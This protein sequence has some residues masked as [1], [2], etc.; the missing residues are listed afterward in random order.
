[1]EDV[2]EEFSIEQVSPEAAGLLG[3]QNEF[4]LDELD[5]WTTT[6]GLVQ[7]VI[8]FSKKILPEQDI[9]VFF[10]E[11]GLHEYREI[12]REGVTTVPDDSLFIG[13]L[14]M[15]TD[16]T[17]LN[18]LFT[19]FQVNEPVLEKVLSEVYHAHTIIPVVH[20]F[21]LLAFIL[22]CTPPESE[23]KT[24]GEQE[25]NF[26]NRLTER[27]TINLYASSIADQRL[28]ELLR[29]TQYPL[30]LQRHKTIKDVYDNLM[31]DIAKEIP[32]DLGICYAYDKELNQLIPFCKKGV[33]NAKPLAPGQGISGQVFESRQPLFI[34][35]RMSHPS[36]AIMQEEPFIDGSV[37][38][39]PVFT[40][41]GDLGVV[42]LVRNPE[43][44][45]PFGME[46]RYMLEIATAFTASE[47]TN[48]Q[49]YTRLDESN[50][51]VVESLTRALEAKD[52]YTEGHSAR[53]TKYAEGI[54]REMGY[55]EEKIHQ[56]RY[57]AM[58]HDI[59]KIGIPD[60]II[61][62]Q[63]RLTDSEYEEIKTHTEIGYNIVCNNPFFKS[64]STFIRYHHETLTGTGYYG[65]KEGEIPE[66]AMIIS[67]A[68]IFDALT[69]DRPYRKALSMD[70]AVQEL[71][72]QSGVHYTE[73]IFEAFMRYLLKEKPLEN[74]N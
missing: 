65:L 43:N 6:T 60:A 61:N 49:L 34:P 45:E 3:L 63:E 20:R 48:R 12:D 59:G 2:T 32:F 58:L 15:I 36:Y 29:M 35:D 64:I 57:G 1:M 26:L 31:K 21:D 66:E 16:P 51:N 46:H 44:K 40:N 27:I 24:L 8:A 33:R 22:V 74:R 62:K 52:S 68:D 50:F 69:S 5:N 47:I 53:V 17:A 38:C 10:H 73:E 11:T 13:C 25:L 42:S 54:A 28:R 14:S 18:K 4:N 39:V 70:E 23:K 37:I 56:L 72:K 55:K 30:A 19:D 7:S 41:S 67:A 71:K 9:R